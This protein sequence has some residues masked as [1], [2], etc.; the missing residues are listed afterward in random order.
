MLKV[1]LKFGAFRS[2]CKSLTTQQSCPFKERNFRAWKKIKTLDARIIFKNIK[3]DSH[4]GH[5]FQFL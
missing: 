2:Q 5:W 1:G 3:T 4:I